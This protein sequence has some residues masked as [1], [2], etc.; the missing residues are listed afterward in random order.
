MIYRKLDENRDYIFGRGKNAY[1]EG[2]DA[3][4]QAIKSRLLL[5]YSEWWEDLEDGLP[6]FSYDYNTLNYSGYTSHRIQTTEKGG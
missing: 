2:A 1:P 5:L 3:V 6:I 4:A